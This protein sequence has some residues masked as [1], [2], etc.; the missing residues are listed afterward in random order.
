MDQKDDLNQVE[1]IMNM[2]KECV[3]KNGQIL[4]EFETVWENFDNHIKNKEN[5]L[6]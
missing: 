6:K 3:D 4:E 2:I 1:H 5:D